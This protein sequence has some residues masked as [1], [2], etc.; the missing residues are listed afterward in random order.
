MTDEP[1]TVRIPRRWIVAFQL[2]GAVVGFGAAF[3]VGPLVGWLLGFVGDAPGLLRLAGSLPLVW[4][5]PVL[6][7]AGLIVGFWLAAQW[8][9]EVGVVT[10]GPESVT[11]FRSGTGSLLRAE[12][13]SGAFTDGKD[14]I[15][16][17]AD[18]NELLRS[19]TDTVLATRLQSAFEQHDYRWQGTV[20]PRDEQFIAW[21]DG[22][23]SLD[24]EAHGLLRARQRA[25]A[26]KR[27]G[28]AEGFRDELAATGIVVRDRDGGQ[29][30]RLIGSDRT[31]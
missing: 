20:D 2:G 22:D 26:D 17:D 28:A 5:I 1:V 18:G 3:I 23:G 11:L 7:I 13:I 21:I 8:Q 24:A 16:V 10:V 12:R 6:T 4:A 27:A 31:V 19:K 9:E 14:L 15:I 30:Y 25:L 29:Q